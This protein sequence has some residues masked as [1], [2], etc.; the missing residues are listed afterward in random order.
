MSA[1]YDSHAAKRAAS[2]RINGDLLNKARGLS[3]DLSAV[4][5]EALIE[6]FRDKQ[7][8]RWL[9]ENRQAIAA[10]NRHVESNGV[11]S[12]DLRSF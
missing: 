2:V 5:E 8:G 11:F 4:L 7:R 3:I 1:I 9:A 12:D 6:A 10:Y